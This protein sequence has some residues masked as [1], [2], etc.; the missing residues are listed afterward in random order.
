MPELTAM[1]TGDGALL[2]FSVAGLAA[3]PNAL[4]M[5]GK[6]SA[7]MTRGSGDF[8]SRT[9]YFSSRVGVAYAHYANPSGV[10]VRRG[11]Y[12]SHLLQPGQRQ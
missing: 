9:P 3:S 4:I 8:T 5:S 11:E 1:I 6:S 2:L 12:V 10:S 7:T